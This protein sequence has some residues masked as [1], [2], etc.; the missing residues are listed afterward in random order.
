MDLVEKI[1]AVLYSDHPEAADDGSPLEFG[2]IDFLEQEPYRNAA[3]SV[4]SC[5]EG[6]GYVIRP[7]IAAPSDIIAKP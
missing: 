3:R 2:E 4:L 6:E 1:A 7:R 5:I